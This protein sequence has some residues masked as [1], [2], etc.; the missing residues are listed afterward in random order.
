MPTDKN[1]AKFYKLKCSKIEVINDNTKSCF[2]NPIVLQENIF[3]KIKSIVS[4][5]TQKNELENMI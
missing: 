3:R 4:I 1:W 5:F 2:P